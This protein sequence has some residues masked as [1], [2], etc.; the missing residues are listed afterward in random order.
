LGGKKT[1]KNPTDRAKQGAK[2]SLLVEADGIPVGLAVDGANRNDMK[3]TQQT[4]ESIPVA[5]PEPTPV[6]PQGLCLDKGYDYDEVRAIVEEFAFT[7]HICARGEEAK[8]IK[9]SARFKA[10]RWV[11]ERTHSWMNRFRGI[12]IRWNKKANNYIAMLHMAFAFII[13]RRMGLIG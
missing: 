8:K 4:L 12:L 13:Y 3:L 9:R 11:V 5:R 1:G 7:A 2:R 10:R 6:A